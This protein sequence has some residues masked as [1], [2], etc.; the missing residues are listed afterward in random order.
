MGKGDEKGTLARRA[1]AMVRA[2]EGRV[3][4]VGIEAELREGLERDC[5]AEGCALSGVRLKFCSKCQAKR[6]CSKACQK[7]DFKRH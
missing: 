3:K 7:K 6:Y 5:A 2:L 4:K 1:P